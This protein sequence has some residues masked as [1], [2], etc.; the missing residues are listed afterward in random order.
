MYVP[1]HNMNKVIG[2][3]PPNNVRVSFQEIKPMMMIQ[4]VILMKLDMKILNVLDK[5]C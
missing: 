3:T 4:A 2:I 5:P 1:K